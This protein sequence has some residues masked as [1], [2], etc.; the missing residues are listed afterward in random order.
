VQLQSRKKWTL[1][2][3]SRIKPAQETL[4]KV[5]PLSKKIGVTRLADITD[6]DILHIPNYSAVVP[7]TEDYIWVYSGKGPTKEH[8]MASA[9]MESIE[10]YS[11][12][13]SVWL[14][15]FV[16]SSFS[17]LSKTQRVLH[18]D[19][20]VEPMRFVYRKDM[21]MDWL[22]GYDLLSREKVMVPASIALFRYTPPPPAV[23]PFAY[24]HTNGLASGNVMEEAICHALCEVIERDAMSLADLRASAIPFHILRTIIHSLNSAAFSIS[25]VLADRFVDDPSI[26]PDID[27]S[28]ID[29]DP[30]KN[31]LEKFKQ[32]GISLTIKDITSDIG[33]PTFNASS[34]EW[35]TH[36]YGYLAE[37]HGTH[38]D[39]RIALLRA[40][41][42]VAQTRAANI[43]GA[44]D[45]LRKIKYNQ[46]N[47]DDKRA[48]QFMPSTKKIKFREVQTFFNEDIIDDINL[49]L[50]RLKRVGL[51][52]A[53][54]VDLTN[55]DIDIPVVRA[56]V[57]GLETFKITKS[58]MG[59]RA[60]A[61]F[62]QWAS[63]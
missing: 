7:G 63:Q 58:V 41:T 24:F 45:D 62:K 2:G 48:W 17:E 5:I 31:L 37:G 10:R 28:E 1:N 46:E 43:Q 57:P 39:A 47:T 14:G 4:K 6:M 59:M 16:R 60:K 56:I 55:Q 35:V 3:T 53:I 30:V 22:P 49:I 20:I 13:P 51:N 36:D 25:P 26:F 61:C 18:P 21:I 42:E 8:A 52:Q 27:I 11:S 9:L 15:N 34:V 50:L 19:S 33:I 40:I 12:L 29:F 32:A 44:R 23:N 38:P 54:I